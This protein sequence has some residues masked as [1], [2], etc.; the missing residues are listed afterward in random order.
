MT[1]PYIDTNYTENTKDLEEEISDRMNIAIVGHVDHGKS[2]IIGRLLADTKSL[3]QGKLEQIKERCK[4]NSKPFEYSFLLDA[5]KDE[6]AQGITIDTARV[7]FNSEKRKYIILDTPGHIEFLRNVV[8]GASRAEAALLIIDAHE[9]IQENSKRYCYMISLLGIKKISIVVNKMDLIDYS[10]T[11][12]LNIV[13][14]YQQFLD[15]I[16]VTPL[17]FIPVSGKLG[18]NVASNSENI[19]WYKGPSILS[20]LDMF[21]GEKIPEDQNFRMSVQDVY[22][23]TENNDKRRIVAGTIESGAISVGEEVVF[24]PSGKTSKIQ[25]I[26][27]FNTSTKKTITAGYATGF[28]IADHLYIKRGQ[29]MARSDQNQP[30]VANNIVVDLFWLGKLPLQYEKEYFIKIGAQKVPFTLQKIRRVIDATNLNFEEKPEIHRNEVAECEFLLKEPIAFDLTHELLL[31]SRFVIVDDFEI[32]GGGIISD[33]I[34]NSTE[35]TKKTN[36]NLS[37]AWE[38]SRIGM[39]DRAERY[40]QK[41][42]LILITGGK[43]SRKKEIAKALEKELFSQGKFVYHMGIG[44]LLYGLDES[45]RLNTINNTD[46]HISRLAEIANIMLDS[47]CILIVTARSLNQSDLELLRKT[48]IVPEKLISVWIG[49]VVFTDIKVD[50]HLF[51]FQ[52]IKRGVKRLKQILQDKGII[53]KI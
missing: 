52:R 50:Y 27:G 53:F 41:S 32:A 48:L 24:L 21:I 26:E 30:H 1:Q 11:K 7:F 14:E 33:I 42:S 37:F 18:D 36:E 25:S 20:Q 49:N 10:E 45:V 43:E 46:N 23:F 29:I 13:H 47:G 17:S 44:H 39:D 4:R 31:T 40:N 12:F 19:P 3:P 35:K 51:N 9:G 2:T 5:L 34:N 6:Q 38:R 8:T 16:Q 28:T 15:K 22:K